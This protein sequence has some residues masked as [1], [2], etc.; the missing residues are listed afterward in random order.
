MGRDHRHAV[1]RRQAVQRQHQHHA[2]RAFAPA[3][4]RFPRLQARQISADFI[5]QVRQARSRRRQDAGKA[6][7]RRHRDV[8]D[9]VVRAAARAARHHRGGKIDAQAR[10]GARVKSRRNFSPAANCVPSIRPQL[11]RRVSGDSARLTRTARPPSSRTVISRCCCAKRSSPPKLRIRKARPSAL[12]SRRCQMCGAG[13]SGTI[14]PAFTK[15]SAK[16]AAIASREPAAAAAL[17]ATAK[18]CAHALE[19]GGAPTGQA[20]QHPAGFTSDFLFGQSHG[21]SLMDSIWQR[22]ADGFPS[23]AGWSR[24]RHLLPAGARSGCRHDRQFGL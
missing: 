16:S 23:S 18:S 1:M 14:Q 9:R 17:R 7:A 2:G 20:A 5:G 15:A 21:A 12:S 8:A 22:G 6:L 19:Q 24:T 3:A 13:P 4:P 10:A 11:F